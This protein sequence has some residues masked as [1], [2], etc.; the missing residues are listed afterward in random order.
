MKSSNL[1][2]KIFAFLLIN[3]IVFVVL[4]VLFFKYF[5]FKNDVDLFAEK[6]KSLG[7]K[8][9]FY[10]HLNQN[11]IA[12]VNSNYLQSLNLGFLSYNLKGSVAFSLK[13][14]FKDSKVAIYVDD[15]SIYFNCPANSKVFF[16]KVDSLPSV[17]TQIFLKDKALFDNNV[18]LRL[19]KNKGLVYFTTFLMKKNEELA[20]YYDENLGIRV[21]Y[22]F[23]GPNSFSEQYVKSLLDGL[24]TISQGEINSLDGLNYIVIN[25][26]KYFYIPLTF[27]GKLN[28]CFPSL[29][30][31]VDCNNRNY[32]LVWFLASYYF[33]LSYGDNEFKKELFN[34]MKDLCNFLSK[35]FILKGNIIL[36]GL[37][38]SKLERKSGEY[39]FI[40]NNLRTF[41]FLVFLGNKNTKKILDLLNECKKTNIDPISCKNK[42]NEL[43]E[44]NPLLRNFYSQ[45]S[46]L[47]FN[48]FYST[49]LDLKEKGVVS[50]F[51]NF[52]E[53][54]RLL[55][56]FYGLRVNNGKVYFY[57]LD[58][59][60]MVEINTAKLNRDLYKLLKDLS[61]S[62]KSKKPESIYGSLKKLN[63]FLLGF[64][65]KEKEDE[66]FLDLLKENIQFLD[67]VNF[68]CELINQN[69][70]YDYLRSGLFI[71]P[72]D[73]PLLQPALAFEAEKLKRIGG[74]W[75]IITN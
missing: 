54:T 56:A 45:F 15:S 32:F 16:D 51:E 33:D 39:R 58:S 75:Y 69:E 17:N 49:Y 70:F 53:L 9:F 25:N 13:N 12:Y 44:I 38:V 27:D 18:N 65:P 61:L 23:K 21:F 22:S 46:F 41:Y 30:Y 57:N 24:E 8:G 72:L 6:W 36:I 43:C 64:V 40:F 62:L 60:K 74:K 31:K 67:T 2:Y 48:K 68:D 73:N 52:R 5:S 50:D 35:D 20:Y 26:K 55:S 28:Y 7:K 37:D 11:V 42:L 34:F 59:K 4:A 14:N 47:S 19:S 63:D 3:F 71:E 29:S 66:E 10:N 1:V